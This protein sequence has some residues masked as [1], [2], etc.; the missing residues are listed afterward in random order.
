MLSL[1]VAEGGHGVPFGLVPAVLGVVPGLLPGF[2]VEGDGWWCWEHI[3]VGWYT[4][5]HWWESGIA[6]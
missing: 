5:K 1:G 3:G 4:G 2:G 6:L